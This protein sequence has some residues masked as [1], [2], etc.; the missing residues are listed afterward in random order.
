[1]KKTRNMF[2]MPTAKPAAT[3]APTSAKRRR[4]AD[5]DPEYVSN[6][7]GTAARTQQLEQEAKVLVQPTVAPDEPRYE[8]GV[9]RRDPYANISRATT[10]YGLRMIPVAE[11]SDTPAQMRKHYDPTALS[12][13]ANS[14][15]LSGLQQPVRVRAYGPNGTGPYQLEHG[16]RRWRA[17]QQLANDPDHVVRERHALVPAIVDNASEI[18]DAQAAIVTA[19][20]NAQR[21]D[22]RP[23]EMARSVCDVRGRLRED[24]QPA[25]DETVGIIFGTGKGV[26]SEYRRIGETITEDVLRAAGAVH[27][28]NNDTDWAVVHQLDKGPLLRAAKAPAER[29]AE[30]LARHIVM[31][32][33][34]KTRRP[35]V[36]TPGQ[37]EAPNYTYDSLRDPE[38]FRTF[39]VKLTKPVSR[40]SYSLSEGRRFLETVEPLVS[41]L[42]DIVAPESV[43]YRPQAPNMPG[44]YLIVKKSLSDLT[45]NERKDVI[46]ELRELQRVIEAAGNGQG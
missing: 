17:F 20:E 14:I 38:S 16:A 19:M 28:D 3:A 5:V 12:E 43:V 46:K 25:Y 33:N 44:A 27:G 35:R 6:V 21:E 8:S 45:P 42:T 15:K 40:E 31:L 41:A 2:S 1:M 24:N 18:S 9:A 36:P 39:Q 32:R 30:I 4:E 37:S 22:L 23:W 34:G 11:I 10:G 7:L 29:R 13:L 26:I